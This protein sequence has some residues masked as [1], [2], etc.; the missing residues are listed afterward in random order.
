[1]NEQPNIRT[2]LILGLIAVIAVAVVGR[3]GGVLPTV[4]FV[5]GCIVTVLLLIFFSREK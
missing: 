5:L 2:T 1:M 4:L 3:M